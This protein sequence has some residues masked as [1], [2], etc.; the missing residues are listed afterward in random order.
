MCRWSCWRSR[1]EVG[2][3][4]D[5]SYTIVL[6][7]SDRSTIIHVGVKR[8]RKRERKEERKSGMKGDI[9]YLRVRSRIV[10]DCQCICS[11]DD[12]LTMT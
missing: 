3:L 10:I 9:N 8:A 7:R 5:V 12:L 2:S 11:R 6:N 1:G 4:G